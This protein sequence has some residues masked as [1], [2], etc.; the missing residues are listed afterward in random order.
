MRYRLALDIGANSIGWCCL[1]LDGAGQPAGIL[2][3]GVR[4]FPDGRNPNDGSSNAVARRQ[5]RAMRR[6]RD[7]YLQRRQ[8]LLNALTRFALM[9]ADEAARRA[10]AERDPWAL[11]AEALTRRLA[12]EELGRVLFHLNQRRGFASNRK[13]DR[14]NEEKGKIAEAADRL[15]AALARA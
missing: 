13:A 8:A 11:R 2:A 10:I 7:R 6:N 9:P 14:G 15:R 12:P 1:R 4:V 3:M 5:A